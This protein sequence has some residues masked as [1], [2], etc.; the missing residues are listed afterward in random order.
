[1]Y[2]PVLEQDI[3]EGTV[4]L[5]K[6]AAATGPKVAETEDILEIEL[7]ERKLLAAPVK[8][9]SGKVIRYDLFEAL[10]KARTK[11]VGTMTADPATGDPTGDATF[12]EE[13]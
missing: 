6:S 7:G 2:H 10:D 5:E 11:V 1:M 4:N 9:D 3:L 12:S 8:D 13:D